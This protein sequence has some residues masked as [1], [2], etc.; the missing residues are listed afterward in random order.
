MARCKTYV[1]C[2]GVTYGSGS[3]VGIEFY[4]IEGTCGLGVLAVQRSVIKIPFALAVHTVYAPVN[5]YAE[6][7]GGKFATAL[8][9]LF[10][11]C[12]LARIGIEA[13]GLHS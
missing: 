3:L 9:H 10:R 1:S 6:T 13:G 2:T 5:E 12:V 11:G 7:V 4:R 8:N